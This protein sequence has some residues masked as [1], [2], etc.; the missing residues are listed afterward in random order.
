MTTLAELE[1][2][3]D[4]DP[5][6][7]R[8]S[9]I[10][11]P[12]LSSNLCLDLRAPVGSHRGG[13]GRGNRAAGIGVVAAAAALILGVTPAGAVIARTVLPAGLQQF[14]GIVSGA[15]TQLTPPG[16]GAPPSRTAPGRESP[17]PAPCSQGTPPGNFVCLPNLSLQEAQRQVDFAIPVPLALPSGLSF[18]GALVDTARSV[19][20]SYRLVN[21]ASG[22]L[23]L[24]ITQGSPVGGPSV[25]ATSVQPAVVDG[26]P[27]YYVAGDYEDAGPGTTAHWNPSADS[28]QLTWRHNGLT[29]DLTSEGLHLSEA[30]LI[31]VA[32]TVQ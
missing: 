20:I 18:R 10:T 9:L 3:L 29:F 23:G 31:A 15:P 19:Y 21:G 5:L 2:D 11:V 8:L 1:R 12:L 4:T 25:P 26:E 28:N 14:F 24:S 27:A 22:G 13:S 30:E 16:G 17:S 32:E 7:L 6:A